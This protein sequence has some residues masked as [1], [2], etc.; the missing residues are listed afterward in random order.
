MTAENNQVPGS[1]RAAAVTGLEV[2]LRW[3]SFLEHAAVGLFIAHGIAEDGAV[4]DEVT[5]YRQ[6]ARCPGDLCRIFGISE[7]LNAY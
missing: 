4:I 3:R 5:D 1:A 7:E 2:P 6:G